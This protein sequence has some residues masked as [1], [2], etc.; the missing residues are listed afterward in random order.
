MKRLWMVVLLAGMAAGVVVAAG[1]VRDQQAPGAQ[2]GAGAQPSAGARLEAAI[3]KEVVDG[4]L[5]TAIELYRTLAQASD[6]AV[7]AKALLRMGQCYEKLGDTDT[8]EARKAY[9]QIVKEFG[10]QTAVAA[11]ARTKLAALAGASGTG[12]STIT[13][14]RIWTGPEADAMGQV[15]PH[16]RFLSFT[17]WETGDLAIHDLT[18]GENRRIT[19]KGA[20]WPSGEYAEFSIVS[21][22]SRQ[23]AYNWNNKDGFYDLRIVEIDGVKPRVVYSDR[24]HLSYIW[25]IAW[26]PDGMHILTYFSKTDGPT[27]LMLV[28]PADG[29]ARLITASGK[30]APRAVFSPDGRYLAY[31]LRENISLFDVAAGREF[32]LIPDP[33]NHSV[34]GWAPDGKHILFSSERSGSPDAWLI[35]VAD[36]KA[37]GEPTLVKKDFS[38]AFLGFTRSGAFYYA[39]ANSVGDV[40]I[41]ELD[42]AS[43]KVV[44]PPQP[45]SRRWVG[46]TRAPDWS[47]DGRSLAYIRAREPSQAVIMVRSIDTGEEREFQVG[48][49]RLGTDLRWAPDGRAIVVP[50]FEPG[51]GSDSAAYNGRKSLTRIDVQT[52]QVTSLMPFP[53][54]VGGSPPFDLSPDGKTAFYINLNLLSDGSQGRNQLLARD[55]QSGQ[56]TELVAK[57]GLNSVSVAPDGQRLVAGVR[58]GRSQVLLVMPAAGGEARELVR[59]DDEEANYRVSPSWTPDGRYVVFGKNLRDTARRPPRVQAWRVAAEGGVPQPM[60]LIVDGLSSLRLHPDGRRIAT[61]TRNVIT[62]VW[63]MENFLPKAAAPIAKAK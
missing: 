46:I 54:K 43:G 39:V 13:V 31:A 11:E 12:A 42:P 29:S 6:R 55:V 49:R 57:R 20:W 2:A 32:P 9:E 45:A 24:E 21:P 28:R 14:R 27:E 60:E 56:E 37:E 30:D 25:P 62:E 3:K 35:T 5:K 59:I 22:D 18:T 33:S 47:P 34:M 17:D 40:Q 51:K 61:S 41:A 8:R 53:V 52:G 44:S 23:I 1:V 48:G 38:G 19:R 4:D 50:G 10:D 15:S 63:V 26:S 7:A 58:E 36:G 16:G